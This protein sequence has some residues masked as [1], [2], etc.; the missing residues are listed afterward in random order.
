MVI[1][2]NAQKFLAERLSHPGSRLVQREFGFFNKHLAGER[3]AVR[4]Q[5]VSFK[6]DENISFA[7][8]RAI[9]HFGAIHNANDRSSDIV[10]AFLIH[11]RHLGGFATNESTA[12][13]FA[14]FRKP[15]EDLFKNWRIELFATDVVEEEKR[16]GADDGDVVDAMVHEILTDRIVPV[17]R[18]GDFE[19]CSNTI[20]ARDENRLPHSFEVRLEKAAKAADFTEHLRSVR[21]AHESVDSFFNLVTE[22][23]IDSGGGIGFLFAWCFQSRREV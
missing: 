8:F 23:Y 19:F 1:R 17:R 15:F 10:F 3:V 9:E 12:S 11:T 2:V 5:S 22:V 14:G 18:E 13:F 6:A 21:A 16:T 7:N 20:H 4:V